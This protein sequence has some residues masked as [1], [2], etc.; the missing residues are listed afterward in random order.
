MVAGPPG[1]DLMANPHGII[2]GDKEFGHARGVVNRPDHKIQLAPGRFLAEARRQLA[3]EVITTPRDRPFQLGNRRRLSSMN[4]YLNDLPGTRRLLDRNQVELNDSDAAALGLK[5]GD[6]ARVR[7]LTGAIELDVVVTDSP[8]PGVVDRRTRL[9]ITGVRST[10]RGTA[11]SAGRQPQPPDRAR[12]GRS[13]VADVSVQRDVGGGRSRHSELAD[14]VGRAD[15]KSPESVQF[16]GFRVCSR[17]NWVSEPLPHVAG[18]LVDQFIA[19]RCS[20][21]GKQEV[22]VEDGGHH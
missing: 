10:W 12:R 19:R 18:Q 14:C 8:R 21:G 5:D 20:S 3:C 7:S 13:A 2:L 9:G 16:R 1:P 4:S 22:G 11:G 6:R 15:A 17:G